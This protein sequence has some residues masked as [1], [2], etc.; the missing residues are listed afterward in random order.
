MKTFIFSDI[1]YMEYELYV[2]VAED[3]ETARKLIKE[4]IIDPWYD[5]EVS[6]IEDG[7]RKDIFLS[8]LKYDL[9]QRLKLLSTEPIIVEPNHAIEVWHANE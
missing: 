9:E 2:A 5:K 4:N 6:K 8:H 3:C 7:P 1:S